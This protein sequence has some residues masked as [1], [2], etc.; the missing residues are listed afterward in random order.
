[1]AAALLTAAAG[2]WWIGGAHGLESRFY[3]LYDVT[4]SRGPVTRIGFAFYPPDK[5]LRVR[6]IVGGRIEAWGKY[7]DPDTIDHML[8]LSRENPDGLFAVFDD[9]QLIALYRE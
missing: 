8:R 4:D 9:N 3:K 7:T 5:Q 2:G 1:M 6:V